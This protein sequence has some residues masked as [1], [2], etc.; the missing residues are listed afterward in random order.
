[1]SE[2]SASALVVD[3]QTIVREGLALILDLLPGISVAGTAADGEQALDLVAEMSPD[4]VLMDLRM[5]RMSGVEATRRILTSRPS[6]KILVLTTYCD[7]ESVTEALRAGAHGYLTKDVGADQIAQAIADVLKGDSHFDAIVQQRLVAMAVA[8]E[9][10][11]R[12]ANGLTPR[13]IDVLRLIAKGRCNNEIAQLLC[14]TEATVKTHIN[15]LFAKIGA[16]TR[17][18]AVTYA[19]QHGLTTALPPHAG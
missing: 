19:F 17:A 16:R 11:R 6:T 3:D 13:E 2:V 10:R 15:N 18:Q 12:T 1:M 4:L 8:G 14:V 5:P 7:D 9:T